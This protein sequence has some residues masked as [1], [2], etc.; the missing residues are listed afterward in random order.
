MFEF[1]KKKPSAPPAK[2]A[3]A[4]RGGARAH[5]A[6]ARKTSPAP[7]TVVQA[8]KAARAGRREGAGSRAG[9]ARRWLRACWRARSAGC[10]PATR[11]WTDDL[12]DEL[13]TALISADV[14]VPPPP[15]WSEGLRKRMK[16]REFADARASARGAARRA[17]G[18]PAPIA[19][20]LEIARRTS[21]S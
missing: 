21:L 7:S 9:A 1:L 19:K 2:D 13:E 10:S 3:R 15:R 5:R 8:E 18:D 4:G 20:P 6:G 14:G 12:L 17:A 11:A 16:A